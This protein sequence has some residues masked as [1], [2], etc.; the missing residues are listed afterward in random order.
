METGSVNTV[1]GSSAFISVL[2]DSMEVLSIKICS[3]N[4]ANGEIT[5]AAA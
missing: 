4:H 1:S 5:Y 3:L 2:S